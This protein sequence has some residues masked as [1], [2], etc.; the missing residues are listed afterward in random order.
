MMTCLS[1]REERDA[2][3]VS[4]ASQLTAKAF[5]FTSDTPDRDY[6]LSR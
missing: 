2:A 5:D 4:A 3:T 1:R 6:F